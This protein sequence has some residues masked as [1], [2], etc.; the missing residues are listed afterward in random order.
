MT[1]LA[2]MMLMFSSIQAQELVADSHTLLLLHLND[3]VSGVAGETP[4]QS[5]G[6]SYS[7]GRFF[8]GASL[9]TGDRL[10]YNSSGNISATNG[11]LEC[12]LK[13]EWNGNDNVTHMILAW[14]AGG[15][16]LMAKDGAN[17]L[18]I[19]LNRYSAGGRPEQG[20]ATNI[21]SWV[22]NQWHHVA[23]TWNSAF[24]VL[25]VDGSL[26]VQNPVT[27]ALPNIT[28]TTFQIGGE[29][30]GSYLNA[31]VD[32]FRLSDTVRTAEDISNTYMRGLILSS[33]S[34]S[35]DSLRMYPTWY[36][37][38]TLTAVTDIGTRTIPPSLASW[39]SSNLTVA[40]VS[41]AGVISALSGGTATITA[42][43]QGFSDSIRI[44]VINPLLQPVYENLDTFLTIPAAQ[45]IYEM[46]V[47]ILTYLPT[48]DGVNLD[49]TLT[50]WDAPLADMRN[51]VETLSIRSKFM[52]E[53]GSKFRGYDNPNARPSLG[54]RVVASIT[55]YEPL[56][57][58]P[59]G[60]DSFQPDYQQIVQRFDGEHFVNDLGV[61]EF[62]LW[63]YHYGSIYPVES[64]MSSP[65]TGDISNSYRLEDLPVYNSTY[66]LYNYNFTRSQA[67]AVHNHGHQLEAILSHVN[68]LQDGNTDLF[69]HQF[70]GQD[71][72]GQTITGR[73]GN[74]HIPPNTYDHYDYLNPATVQSDIRD[75]MPSGG[76]TTAVNYHTWADHPYAWPYGEWDFGQREESQWYIFWMQ[77]MPGL[78]NEIPY[79]STTMTNWW[80]FTAD[81][82][83]AIT[84]QM[85]LYGIQIP[86]SPD[87]VLRVQGNDVRLDWNSNGNAAG[88]QYQIFRSDSLNGAAALLQTTSDTSYVHSGGAIGLRGYYHVVATNIARYLTGPQTQAPD[89]VPSIPHETRK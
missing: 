83:N 43:L 44:T 42:N 67:E 9:S 13:P 51:L 75:W 39:S 40:G 1:A 24:M 14:G 71:G 63:G 38:P 29:G 15:G 20:V 68:W 70:S 22:A 26:V 30:A 66:V 55:I 54:Y 73:C 87:V 79:N 33:L 72:S 78:H 50:G 57:L 56:P 12:W 19:I 45:A 31:V 41:A 49:P 58:G 16:L 21:G 64:N 82:D 61:K 2:A 28:A 85:G 86:T 53:E 62:W 88:S 27:I 7:P 10:S 81:W 4:T 17:N 77:S 89:F 60:P 11:S 84:Q 46:P 18:R 32:E 3:S 52:L 74:T 5:I 8:N 76:A 48:S 23:F 37:T 34:A 6:V 59:G 69:W 25:Y 35:P 47:V 80:T 65:T 36:S